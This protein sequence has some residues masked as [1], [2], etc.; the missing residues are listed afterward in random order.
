MARVPVFLRA[1]TRLDL[2]GL[3]FSVGWQ[4]PG[5]PLQFVPVE[6]GAPSLTDTGV[7]G[8]MAVAWLNGLQIS[9][10]N[11]LIGYIQVSGVDPAGS[12]SL[13]FYGVDAN[14][15]GDGRSVQ[16]ATPQHP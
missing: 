7:P 2:A 3:S 13:V 6:I 4:G 10:G 5:N 11:A 9:G 16:F 12:F 8:T 15:S 14:T 1:G